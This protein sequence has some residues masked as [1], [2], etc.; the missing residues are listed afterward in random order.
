MMTITKPHKQG[1]RFTSLV[2]RIFSLLNLSRNAR[3]CLKHDNC[4]LCT[5][6]CV[7]ST[8]HILFLIF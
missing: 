1:R 2:L 3:V 5:L 6:L 4:T 8:L 7:K